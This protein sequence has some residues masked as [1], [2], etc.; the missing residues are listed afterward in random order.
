MEQVPI[1]A[2]VVCVLVVEPHASDDVAVPN[3]ASMSDAIGLHP[4][5]RVVPPAI[6]HGGVVS[7]FH[8]TIL[9]AVDILPHPSLAVNVLFCDRVHPLLETDP[10]LGDNT[11]AVLHPSVAVAVPNAALISE[12]D[13]LQPKIVVVP[14]VD[15]TGP[16]LS[17]VHVT[18]LQAVVVFPHPSVAVN[19]LFCERLQEVPCS[20]PSIKLTLAVLHASVAVAVPNAAL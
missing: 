15:N 19:I 10:S 4:N 13:G 3:A 9:H 16:V 8:V 6:S 11:V 2:S 12:A 18:V 17:N 5:A 7:S 1:G 14:P 20:V